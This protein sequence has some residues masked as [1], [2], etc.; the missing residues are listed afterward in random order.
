MRVMWRAHAQKRAALSELA[1]NA[2]TAALNLSPRLLLDAVQVLHNLNPAVGG[3][4]RD[5]LRSRE[6]RG[7]AS[8][9][10]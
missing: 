5:D 3:I 10:G 1:A 8:W 9:E 2:S 6:G 4:G 7:G